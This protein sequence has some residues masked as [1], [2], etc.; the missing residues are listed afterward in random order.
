MRIDLLLYRRPGGYNVKKYK[1]MKKLFS[2]LVLLILFGVF[3][4]GMPL[5]AHAQFHLLPKLDDAY[6]ISQGQQPGEISRTKFC[7]RIFKTVATGKSYCFVDG[8]TKEGVTTKAACDAVK[9]EF[10]EEYRYDRKKEIDIEKKLGER[11]PHTESILACAIIAGSVR[12]WMIPFYIRYFSDFILAI[13]GGICILVIIYGAYTYI[14]GSISSEGEG[15][16]SGKKIIKWAVVGLALVFS[17]WSIV[18]ILMAFL[19]G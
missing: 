17:A 14:I 3:T 8:A 5:S 1:Y 15:A 16:N 4:V 2:S 11:D 7:S 18:N 12:L 9:G 19:T 10:K 6:I 13:A